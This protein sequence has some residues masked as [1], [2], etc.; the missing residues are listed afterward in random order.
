MFTQ[1]NLN[2]KIATEN[3]S[4]IVKKHLNSFGTVSLVENLDCL[5]EMHAWVR[6]KKLFIITPISAAYHHRRHALGQR[7]N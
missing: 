6:I 2:G 7:V 3:C 4:R 5:G 1:S